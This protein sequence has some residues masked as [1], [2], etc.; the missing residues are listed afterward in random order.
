MLCAGS[1]P[2][3]NRWPSSSKYERR[4]YRASMSRGSMISIRTRDARMSLS[5]SAIAVTRRTRSGSVSG[6]RSMLVT[7]SHVLFH[8]ERTGC[9]D[10]GT[11]REV[12]LRPR[13]EDAHAIGIGIV[14]RQDEGCF[15]KIEFASNL[16]HALGGNIR[17]VR[18]NR[19]WITAER[20][21]TKNIDDVK[22][23]LHEIS[24]QALTTRSIS[25]Q[26]PSGRAATP[27]AVRAG[28]GGLKCLA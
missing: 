21:R 17:R 19:Q 12:E 23:V 26:A 8:H 18:E 3:S 16:L 1:K 22:R 25:T 9:A 10:R 15:A 5:T 27:I 7:K 28:K 6:A 13:R 4:Q 20:C 11:P 14:L 24:P 2:I